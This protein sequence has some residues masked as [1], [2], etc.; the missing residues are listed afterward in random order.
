MRKSRFTALVFISA[1]TISSAKS[2]DL[3]TAS[4]NQFPTEFW[5]LDVDGRLP[6]LT[7]TQ[8]TPSLAIS[9]FDQRFSQSVMLANYHLNFQEG[10]PTL[11]INV[12]SWALQPASTGGCLN[13]CPFSF[14]GAPSAQGRI[15]LVVG[16]LNFHFV[17][18]ASFI[19][20]SDIAQAFG[21]NGGTRI[22]SYYGGGLE[23]GLTN[24][25][26]ATFDIGQAT[27][28]LLSPF[29]ENAK[30][31]NNVFAAGL[32]FHFGEQTALNDPYPQSSDY[33]KPPRPMPYPLPQPDP[34]QG[35]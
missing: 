26:T 35:Q 28:P 20:S 13:A 21:I 11:S 15:Q 19:N 10:S 2:A 32:H 8:P 12:D 23:L 22:S 6:S 24:Q 18:G 27:N 34:R 3:I 1:L 7:F 17:A 4:S 33:M 31:I 5:M 30:F 25:V 29:P 16:A 14:A 9:T